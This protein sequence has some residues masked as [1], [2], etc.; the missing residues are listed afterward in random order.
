MTAG[1]L[2]QDAPSR[3]GDSPGFDGRR[4][5]FVPLTDLR[6]KREDIVE[7]EAV[8]DCRGDVGVEEEWSELRGRREETPPPLETRGLRWQRREDIHLREERDSDGLWED[9]E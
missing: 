4:V 8:R 6:E 5:S 1:E 2:G 3:T 9:N 7:G